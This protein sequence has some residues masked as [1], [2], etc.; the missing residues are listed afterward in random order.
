MISSITF[1]SSNWNDKYGDLKQPGPSKTA[2]VN[3]SLS[4]W[5]DLM[6]FLQRREDTCSYYYN[7]EFLRTVDPIIQNFQTKSKANKL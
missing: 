2:S 5:G 7:K 4:T 3:K 1:I 6:T